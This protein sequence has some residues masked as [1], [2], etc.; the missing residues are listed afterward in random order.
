MKK[1]FSNLTFWVVLSIILGIIIG[2]F[3]PKIALISIFD[4]E[5]KFN[6]LL[7]DYK[8][9]H[10]LSEVLSGTFISIVKFFIIPIVFVTISLG[11]IQSGDLKKVGKLGFKSILYFEIVT[12]LALL[13]GFATCTLLQPGKGIQPIYGSN[14]IPIVHPNN[15][16]NFFQLFIE[17]PTLLVLI[18]SIL[19]G[20]L[21]CKLSIQSFILPWLKAVSKYLFKIL[22]K[23]ML[24]APIGAFGGMCFTIAKYGLQAIMPLAYL[25]FAVYLTMFLFIF[26]VLGLLL[27]MYHINIWKFLVYMKKELLI[28]LGT[29]SSE[30]ALPNLMEKLEKMG[31][32][33]EVVGV[34]V[35]A[36]YSFNL[37]GTSIYLS[38]G[39]LFLAQVYNIS[40]NMH[41]ILLLI[42]LLMLT[43]K[44]AAGV[45][46]SGLII[47]TSTLTSFQLI[48]TEGIA[49]LLGIDR[50]MSEIRA[51]TNFIGNGV[52]TIWLSNQEK[53]FD[54]SKMERAFNLS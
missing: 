49:L 10:T 48:P 40:L 7:Q 13:I 1:T 28:V 45:T 41:Q 38:M 50:F 21:V 4:K 44:G 53:S 52:A 2:H 34:V 31:C 39:V 18:L 14:P 22:H 5:I 33:K 30:P 24:L 11:I 12:T 37:D 29:S 36:G 27:R 54:R 8:I 35:P 42:G 9:G 26:V 20:I 16:F 25:L 17:N 46:G 3:F 47:L 51:I 6:F 19:F 43:S 32:E 23:V 15:D